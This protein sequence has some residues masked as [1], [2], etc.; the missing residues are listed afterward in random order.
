MLISKFRSF[1]TIS[2]VSLI[3]F[4]SATVQAADKVT[5]DVKVAVLPFTVNAGDDLSYLKESLPEL[6]S[7]RLKEAGFEV[8]DIEAIG[9]L[10]DEK[11][12]SSISTKNARELGL[13]SGASFSVYGSLNQIGDD[14]TLDARLVDSYGNAPG[15]KISVTKEGLINLLPAVDDLVDRMK[16]DLLRLDIIAEVDVE[17]TKVLDKDVV[18]MRLTLQKG[19][20]LTAKSVNTALK[21]IYDLGYFDDVEVKV[22]TIPDGKKVIFAV[23]E[24]PRIQA[25][26]VRG[27]DAIDSEDI[28]EAISTKKGGVVNPKVL[29]DDIRLIRE[30]Y[31]RDGYYKAKVT[32]EVEDAGAGVARLT[33]VIDEGPKLYIQNV[34]IDGAKQ[35]DPD[36]I[37]DVLALKERGMFSWISNSGV[38]KEE[39]LD[40]DAAAI[41]AFYQSKGFIDVKVGRPQVDIKDEGIDVVYQVWE[42]ERYKMGNVLFKG[43]LIEENEKLLEVISIDQLNADNDYFDRSLLKKDVDKLTTHYNNYG[44]AYADVK[45]NIKDKP[46]EKIV[47]VVYDITKH[48]R[49]HI[50]RVL[51]EGNT[52]TRDNVIMREMRLADGDMFN[53]KKLTR[54][55]QRLNNLG[56]FEKVDVSPVPT[57][58]P[59]EMDLVVKVKDKPTGQISGG[60]GYSTYDSVYFA[61]NIA[62][63]NLFGKG[64][65]LSLNGAFSGKK[66]AFA[67]QFKNPR[68]NDTDVGFGAEIYNRSEEFSTYDKKSTGGVFDFSYPIGEYSAVSWGYNAEYYV[69]DDIDD[70]ASTTIKDDSGAHFLSKLIGTIARDTRDSYQNART[71]TRTVFSINFAGGPI[72]GTDDFV[73][74]TGEYNWWTPAFE[75]VVFHSKFWAGF[76]H[77]NF[78]GSDIPADERFELGGLSSVRGYSNEAISP[79]DGE[80]KTEGGNKAF[81]LNLEFKRMLSKEYGISTLAFFDA[82]NAWNEK[83][84]MFSSQVREGNKPALIGLYKSVGAGLNWYSPMGPIGFMY[85]Y[86]LDK[87]GTSGRHKFELLMGQQF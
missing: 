71:G 47:D 38:L 20:M 75:E 69:L 41:Q 62:E 29:A 9:R 77:K 6:L 84:M 51:V 22:D 59:E 18:L 72:G 76:V 7:D 81:Y 53:G 50:R 30:M 68:V 46:E 67:L 80:G 61:A 21:N 28:I 74:Y 34:V 55:T 35:M 25:L 52:V 1:V 60:I 57:G 64:Y 86:G 63:S 43:D 70:D 85:G 37:K 66:T 54:S 10:I 45:V 82:G 58:N 13:L 4:L 42:G 15:K 83:E 23:K 56:Y 14:L 5:Q 40:R 44:Y 27:S 3:I 73:K 65:G 36:D 2:L 78:G 11:G 39:L 48:Q 26:G 33:F 32:H 17:G 31:R 79:L 19:D 8:V 49:V 12:I 87:V 24:K 16:M